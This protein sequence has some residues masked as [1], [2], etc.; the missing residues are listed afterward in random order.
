MSRKIFNGTPT[1][2]TS[3]VMPKF[4]GDFGE[5][6]QQ[7]FEK[8]IAS[9]KRARLIKVVVQPS[10]LAGSYEVIIAD[11]E[12]GIFPDH[13]QFVRKIND[14]WCVVRSPKVI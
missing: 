1:N 8:A 10:K 3:L 13:P 6:E 12:S 9:E 14:K 2:L 11:T 4:S 7:T 5:S